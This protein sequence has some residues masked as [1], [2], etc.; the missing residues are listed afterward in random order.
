[1]ATRAWSAALGIS[2]EKLRVQVGDPVLPT[3]ATGPARLIALYQWRRGKGLPGVWV[4]DSASGA[5]RPRLEDVDW[6]K[7]PTA[8]AQ[9]ELMAYEERCVRYVHYLLRSAA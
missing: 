3:T 6:T 2:W 7:F 5:A 9:G 8:E 4:V 1:M